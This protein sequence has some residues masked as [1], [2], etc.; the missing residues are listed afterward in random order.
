MARIESLE[1]QNDKDRESKLASEVEI[2]KMKAEKAIYARN[3]K[4]PYFEEAKDKIH[5][6]ESR[7]TQ[8]L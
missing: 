3:P 4:L 2:E 1:R 7:D 6:W 5:C 8:C